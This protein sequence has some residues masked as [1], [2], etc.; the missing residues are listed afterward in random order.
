M[1]FGPIP[2]F[3]LSGI[4]KSNGSKAQYQ[5]QR[6][7]SETHAQKLQ[8]CFVTRALIH[9]KALLSPSANEAAWDEGGSF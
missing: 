4:L 5:Y 3:Q 8:L 1:Y 7:R 9:C 6:E 2:H